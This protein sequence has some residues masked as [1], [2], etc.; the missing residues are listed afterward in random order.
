M[1]GANS[2][3]TGLYLK[4][5]TSVVTSAEPDAIDKHQQPVHHQDI[6]QH[7]VQPR[8]QSQKHNHLSSSGKDMQRLYHKQSSNALPLPSPLEHDS[9]LP[10][11]LRLVGRWRAIIFAPGRD[12]RLAGSQQK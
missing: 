8:K 10:S 4:E 11:L 12:Q 6:A 3:A 9:R 1:F 5:G 7:D 2:A